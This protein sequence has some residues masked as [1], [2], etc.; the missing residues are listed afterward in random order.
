M[1]LRLGKA[2]GGTLETWLQLQ[3]AH[4][5]AQVRK[6]ESTIRVRTLADVRRLEQPRLL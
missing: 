3:M 2:S 1:A 4:D 5:L 6:R